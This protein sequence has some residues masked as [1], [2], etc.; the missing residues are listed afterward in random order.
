MKDF[1]AR[2]MAFLIC[3]LW[4]SHQTKSTKNV[5]HLRSPFL[6][7]NEGKQPFLKEI[8]CKRTDVRRKAFMPCGYKKMT[9]QPLIRKENKISVGPLLD[10]PHNGMTCFLLNNIRSHNLLLRKRLSLHLESFS[11]NR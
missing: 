7:S 8:M 3:G 1:R 4:A 10:Y 11:F 6:I 2:L 9:D 5:F